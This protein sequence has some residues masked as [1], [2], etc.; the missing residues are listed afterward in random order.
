MIHRSSSGASGDGWHFS[1]PPSFTRGHQ[2]LMHQLHEVQKKG[3]TMA[4]CGKLYELVQVNLKILS[5]K[6]AR[7]HLQESLRILQAWPGDDQNP[8]TA[9]T[10]RKLVI[11]AAETEDLHQDLS[12]LMHALQHWQERKQGVKVHLETQSAIAGTLHFLRFVLVGSGDVKQAIQYLQEVMQKEQNLPPEDVDQHLWAATL[13]QLGVVTAMTGDLKQAFMHLNESLQMKHAIYGDCANPRAA[14]TLHKL[15]AVTKERGHLQQALR[16][17]KECLQMRRSLNSGVDSGIAA[18]L[19]QIGLVTAMTGDLRHALQYLQDSL[20]VTQNLHH[21]DHLHSATTLIELGVVTGQMGDL[22]QA[23]KYLQESL[24]IQRSLKSD[25]DPGI[26]ST[27]HQL[28][29]VVGERGDLQQAVQYLNESLAMQQALYG[30]GNS[31]GVA[32]TLHMLGYLMVEAGDFSEAQ[33]YLQRSF[34]M[35]RLRGK[36]AVQGAIALLFLQDDLRYLIECYRAL[37]LELDYQR[38]LHVSR[39][40]LVADSDSNSAQPMRHQDQAP[41]DGVQQNDEGAPGS[42]RPFR[43]NAR[44]QGTSLMMAVQEALAGNDFGYVRV[45]ELITAQA[46]VNHT[47][48]SPNGPSLLSMVVLANNARLTTMLCQAKAD[49]ARVSESPSAISLAHGRRMVASLEAMARFPECYRADDLT[50]DLVRLLVKGT[51][52]NWADVHGRTALHQHAAAQRLEA[53]SLLVQ[54]K[55]RIDVRDSGGKAPMDLVPE[56][57]EEGAQWQSLLS[58][59]TLAVGFSGDEMALPISEVNV[60]QDFV[61]CVRQKLREYYQLRGESVSYFTLRI[62]DGVSGQNILQIGSWE[63]LGKPK[64]VTIARGN[65]AVQ[66]PD[67]EEQTKEFLK[68]AGQVGTDAD[69]LIRGHLLNFQDPN[70]TDERGE[71][72][73]FKASRNSDLPKLEILELGCAD[74]NQD[75]DGA[76]PLFVVAQH[77]WLPGA[78]FLVLYKA[79][80]DK[81]FKTNATPAYVAAQNGHLDVVGFLVESNAKLDARTADG[82][83]PLFIASQMGHYGIVQML[84]IARSSLDLPN[85]TGA[86]ALFIAA[87]QLGNDHSDIVELL[88]S[89]HANLEQR[90]AGGA[91]PVYIAAQ[92]GCDDSLTLLLKAEANPNVAAN[93][94]ATPLLIAS[95]NG[96]QS[97]A[98]IL[99]SSRAL[100]NKPMSTF[101]TPLFV[102][103]Q[104]GHL[105]VAK[106]LV[107]WAADVQL[108]LQNGTSPAYVAAQNGHK[109]MIKFLCEKKADIEATGAGGAT[110]FFI[111]AQNGRLGVL[112]FLLEIIKLRQAKCVFD[113]VFA[114]TLTSVRTSLSHQSL[115]E[116]FLKFFCFLLAAFA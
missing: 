12:D 65:F 89:W 8:R 5:W 1:P 58:F 22:T 88:L 75:I 13:D 34:Q 11:V 67:T 48:H 84:L 54:H 16:Y 71:T 72:A 82:A 111:A 26:A 102:S 107:E 99:L 56:M 106:V 110:A 100:V 76:T 43:K 103:A 40:G 86:A 51:D 81:S 78:K 19:H 80:V 114:T 41:S 30:T 15:G 3:E 60:Q 74:F 95:Q 83:T 101:A 70:V 29:A 61:H 66:S 32:L 53:A 45:S 10:L 64:R 23:E 4:I 21:G 38:V 27:L 63:A 109:A 91:S 17:L 113:S 73:A 92:K 59:V 9:D 112:Q 14:A 20:G 108:S 68:L 47:C 52:I 87:Q 37:S 105:G 33:Q 79:E 6:T 35:Q 44:H 98:G 50:P 85:Q 115:Y 90:T 93:D 42:C 57:A 39:S 25:V 36:E 94:G 2:V 116:C 7:Q 28:G 96:H 49:V 69:Q 18:T 77:G 31:Y 55:A 104:N 62:M 46:D 24:R 97:S